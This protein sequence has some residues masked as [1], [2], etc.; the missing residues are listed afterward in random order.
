MMVEHAGLQY[1]T[2]AAC[3]C[4]LTQWAYRRKARLGVKY[5]AE[6]RQGTGWI[7]GTQHTVHCR[8]AAM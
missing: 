6:K 1:G 8:H 2:G 3:H 5:V 4:A 7:S